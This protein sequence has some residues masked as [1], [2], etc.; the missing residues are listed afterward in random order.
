MIDANLPREWPWADSDTAGGVAE[1]LERGVYYDFGRD[2]I[3]AELE[4]SV[5]AWHPDR[6]NILGVNSGTNG[7]L[8]AYFAAGV[9]PGDHV[10]GPALTFHA[11]LT[12]ALLLGAEI[13][14][15]DC[16][17]DTGRI[18]VAHVRSLVRPNTKVVVV[19]H[20]WG[21]LADVISLR[22]F[23]DSANLVLVEDC[24]H[25]H[26]ASWG[27][28]VSGQV[29]DIAVYSCGGGKPVSGGMGG[30]FITDRRDLYERALL[31]GHGFERAAD[32]VLDPSLAGLGATGLG[33]NFRL[34][35]LSALVITAHWDSLEE[36]L[37]RRTRNLSE[38]AAIL[39]M[40]SV[41]Q[42]PTSVAGAY[43]GGH[44]GFKALTRSRDPDSKE[45]DDYLIELQSNGVSFRRATTTVLVQ[46][47][48][49]AHSR[50]RFLPNYSVHRIPTTIT[51]A[52]EL[53]GRLVSVP[54]RRLWDVA[55][56]YLA[57]LADGINRVEGR[58]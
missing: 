35:T 9:G 16:E 48:L 52:I 24:S 44:Y 12:P 13:S 31:L 43:H 54:E 25:A 41:L 40:S 29:G 2:D 39:D 18:D 14:L 49:F 28:V 11:T 30:I 50:R 58:S 57:Q 19:T 23:C 51:N 20:L 36:R 27:G 1:A 34:P 38:L 4:R 15:A 17:P 45:L 32:E 37:K 3:T 26:G 56:P 55:D 22:K 53:A 8:S 10:I 46:Q 21:L 6:A 47:E 5:Q 7:L 42:A 33:A